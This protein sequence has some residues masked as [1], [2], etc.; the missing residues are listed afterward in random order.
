MYIKF[1]IY[2][3]TDKEKMVEK[4]IECSEYTFYYDEGD[5]KYGTFFI[6]T[7]NGRK[8]QRC[9]LPDTTAFIMNDRGKT[10]DKFIWTV[11]KKRNNI[12]R[13]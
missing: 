3:E 7:I 5:W 4:T 1:M 9:F 2:P 12:V 11:D 10:I 8:E 13:N 6:E